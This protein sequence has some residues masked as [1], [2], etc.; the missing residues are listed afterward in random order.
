MS[1]ALDFIKHEAREAVFPTLFFFLVFHFGI[2]TK[3][4][5]LEAYSVSPGDVA[6]ALIGALIVAKAILVIDATPLARPF[7]GHPLLARIVWDTVL[8]G[9]LIFLFK[10][11]EELIPVWLKAP[12][13][14]AAMQTVVDDVSWPE[15]WAVQLWMA[16]SV[17]AYA[18]IIRLDE[19]FGAGSIRRA[20][21]SAAPGND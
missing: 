18:T 21:F 11:L 8:Y 2:A 13:F 1:K 19:Y 5:I 7:A 14:S 20:L 12:S 15:F 17:F 4:L 10:L 9:A 6:S 3:M 16:V